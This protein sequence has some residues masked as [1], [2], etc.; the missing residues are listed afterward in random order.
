MPWCAPRHG[1]QPGLVTTA[2]ERPRGQDAFVGRFQVPSLNGHDDQP[3]RVANL[4]A[5]QDASAATM[6]SSLPL[7]HEPMAAWSIDLPAT[8]ETG[9]TLSTWCGQAT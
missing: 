5:P 2:P 7:V 3:H 4:L 9:L 8:S 1:P 6:S